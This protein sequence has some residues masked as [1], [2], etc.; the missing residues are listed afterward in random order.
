MQRT[1]YNN[2][3]CR[4]EKER[5]EDNMGMWGPGQSQQMKSASELGIEKS[6]K[7][8]VPESF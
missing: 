8:S 2:N 5:C 1:D 6:K 4:L 7:G 3:S